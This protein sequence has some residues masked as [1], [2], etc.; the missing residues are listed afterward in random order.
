MNMK[1]P[2]YSLLTTACLLGLGSVF[3]TGRIAS[4]ADADRAATA[5]ATPAPDH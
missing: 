4:M 2:G 1:L 3:E 5:A